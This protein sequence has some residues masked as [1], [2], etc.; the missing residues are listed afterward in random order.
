M[1]EVEPLLIDAALIASMMRDSMPVEELEDLDR[2]L[3][4]VRELIS[5]L[6]G[7]EGAIGGATRDRRCDAHHF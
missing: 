5:K 3:A 6:R 1:K 2:D 4:S 7:D